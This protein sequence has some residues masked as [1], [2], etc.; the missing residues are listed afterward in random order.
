[1]ALALSPI[2]ES[3]FEARDWLKVAPGFYFD[4]RMTVLR[5]PGGQLILHSP[6]SL[7]QELKEAVDSLGEVGYIVAPNRF[8]HLFA[9]DWKDAYPEATLMGP[10]S[11]AK[12]RKDL[13]LDRALDEGTPEA[14][15]G[16]LGIHALEGAPF[17]D[18]AVF[19]HRASGTLLATD[20]LFNMQETKGALTPMILAV[21]GCNHPPAQSWDI[22]LVT[23]DKEASAR[24]VRAILELDFDRLIIAHGEVIESGG[25]AI[26]ASAFGWLF[27]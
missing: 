1:M 19:H 7:N 25:K 17:I 27:T 20:I 22:K 13:T 9:G 6:L 15:E 11:L 3:I 26:L 23:R 12:K 5:L 10:R 14:W 21:I 8:H 4:V 18:E 16:H 24:S 2:T